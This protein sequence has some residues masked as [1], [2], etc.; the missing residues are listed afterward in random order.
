MRILEDNARGVQVGDVGTSDFSRVRLKCRLIVVLNWWFLCNFS[1]TM[2]SSCM[3]SKLKILLVIKFM[4]NTKFSH[5]SFECYF[6]D[7]SWK[8]HRHVLYWSTRHNNRGHLEKKIQSK[9]HSVATCRHFTPKI[10]GFSILE[11]FFC[12]L[13]HACIPRWI[14]FHQKKPRAIRSGKERI[15]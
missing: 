1:L 9:Q 3:N 15:S 4:S 8:S 6:G 10:D 5:L 12:P 7:N 11:H 14:A 13:Y 2:P